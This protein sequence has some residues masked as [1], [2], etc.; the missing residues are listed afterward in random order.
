MDQSFH[1]RT[2]ATLSATGQEKVKKGF[3]PMVAGFRQVPYNDLAA[4]CAAAKVNVGAGTVRHVSDLAVKT[5]EE[6]D[7]AGDVSSGGAHAVDFGNLSIGVRQ[8]G[9]IEAVFGDELLMA[10]G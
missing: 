9:K 10:L 5:D 1:G 7:P 8:Q 3:D 4:A 6:A 2:M